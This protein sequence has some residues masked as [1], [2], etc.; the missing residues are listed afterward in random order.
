MLTLLVFQKGV[1]RVFGYVQPAKPEMKVREYESYRAGYCGLCMQLKRDYGFLSRM[2]LNYD[3]VTVALLADGLSGKTSHACQKRCMAS[4][5]RRR[6]MQQETP[7]LQLAAGALV[8]LSWY[9]LVDDASDE[10]G[11]RRA[12]A[13]LLRMGLKRAY[14]KAAAAWPTLDKVLAEETAHQQQLEK[15]KS[16]NPEEAAEPSGRM[17]AA[18]FELCAANPEQKHIL[19]RMGLFMGKV[20][21]WLDAAEDWEKDRQKGR[22]N[23]FLRQGLDK[24]QTVEHTKMLCNLAAA[25]AARCYNLLDLVLNKP[26]LDNIVFLGLP[27]G[28]SRAGQPPQGQNKIA[29]V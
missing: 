6:C 29:A 28:I 27:A 11:V 13:L 14:R 16:K 2:F 7:G 20:I 18:I 26:I 3:L 22:Y 12:A 21:Y 25:E 19:S 1:L 5:F 10:S 4:P 24:Q 17:T 8:L 9:K 15:A 23:V